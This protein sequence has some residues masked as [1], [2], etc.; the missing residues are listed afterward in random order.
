MISGSIG[1]CIVAE[2]HNFVPSETEASRNGF[3]LNIIMVFVLGS[4]LTHICVCNK[5]FSQF[6]NLSIVSAC[7]MWNILFLCA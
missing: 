4:S 6:S 1:M 7:I 3:I 2:V 5:A